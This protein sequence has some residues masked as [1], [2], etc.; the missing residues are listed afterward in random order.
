MEIYIWNQSTLITD[1]DGQAAT[2]AIQKQ[3]ANDFLPAWN[4][5]AVLHYVVRGM[6]S[7]AGSFSIRLVDS[8]TIENALGYHETTD[9]FVG[10][11]TCADDGVSWSSCLSH[12]VLEAIAD[13]DCVRCY[14]VE[15]AVVA[16]E[17]CDAPEGFTYWIDGVEVSDFCLPSYFTLGHSPWSHT[18]RLSGPWPTLG[19][20]GYY[21][22]AEIGDWQQTNA[23][24]IRA[25][26]RHAGL[27]SR[28]SRRSHK[29]VP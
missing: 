25:S 4:L 28:R 2:N 3:V 23:M 14:Q 26:K 15:S 10:V 18:G 9:G 5:G 12:E 11:K 7:P 16:L 29:Q 6:D 24:K 13:I 20:G 1:V 27:G 21:S 22:A 17:V 19:P 8:I